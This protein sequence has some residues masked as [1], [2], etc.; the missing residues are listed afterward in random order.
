MNGRSHFAG[1]LLFDAL[2][3]ESEEALLGHYVLDEGSDDVPLPPELEPDA[4]RLST[5]RHFE[6]TL[7]YFEGGLGRVG[8]DGWRVPRP[9]LEEYVRAGA[10]AIIA[11]VDSNVVTRDRD[12]YEEARGFLHAAVDFKGAEPVYASDWKS[13]LG[14]NRTIVLK[15]DQMTVS[16]WLKPVYENVGEIVVGLPAVLTSVESILASGNRESTGTLLNDLWVDQHRGTAPL[17][18]VRALGDGF[19]VFIAANVSDDAWAEH[20]HGNITWILNCARF[21]EGEGRADAGRR[22]PLR[23]LQAT[24]IAARAVASVLEGDE[25]GD[26][27]SEHTSAAVEE[28]TKRIASTRAPAFERARSD[29]EQLFSAPLWAA[30]PSQAQPFLITGEVLRTELDSYHSI[31]PAFDFSAIV[32]CYS[33]AVEV[34]LMKLI[35]EPFR[36]AR[37]WHELPTAG[38]ALQGKSVDHLKRY[39]S[40]GHLSLGQ[41]ARCLENVGCALRTAD[42]NGF[43]A[44]LAEIV[45]D[46]DGLCIGGLPRR[47]IEYVDTYR[48]RAAHVSSMSLAD[49]VK[50]REYLLE[51]PTK[52]LVALTA[53][54]NAQQQ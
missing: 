31:E 34:G 12:L 38:T 20:T 24:L 23:E 33:K 18:S 21:L 53:Y 30:L 40:G 52:L 37:N 49:C 43:A 6:P 10:T 5:L 36:S 7:I 29:L 2:R 3:A 45:G 14:S 42:Q 26:A 8:E 27:L 44:W 47:L 50:A 16:R 46:F 28:E 13:F 41:M 51:E 19:V 1:R 11:D 9:L 39:L 25:A 32:L 54:F 17:A 15:P 35:F 22:A 48:N 4:I